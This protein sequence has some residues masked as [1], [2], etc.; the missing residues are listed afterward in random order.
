MFTEG[1]KRD[2][3]FASQIPSFF[4]SLETEL[5]L[6]NIRLQHK[7]YLRNLYNESKDHVEWNGGKFVPKSQ[8][9]NEI[10]LMILR[11]DHNHMKDLKFQNVNFVYSTSALSTPVNIDQHSDLTVTCKT[12]NLQ[13]VSTKLTNDLNGN[14]LVS[15]IKKSKN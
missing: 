11:R 10:N 5:A 3:D 2:V 4:A 1:N 7:E 14:Q 9:L 13:N 6:V 12:K 8:I 15:R